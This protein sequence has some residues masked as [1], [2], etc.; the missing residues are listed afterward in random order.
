MSTLSPLPLGKHLA[1]SGLLVLL[2]SGFIF[3][4]MPSDKKTRDRA[5]QGLS[6]FLCDGDNAKLSEKDLAKL[7]K[8]IFYCENIFSQ[9]PWRRSTFC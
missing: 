2:A 4:C 8:G 9:P 1:S 3:S 7:W 5:V 6:A